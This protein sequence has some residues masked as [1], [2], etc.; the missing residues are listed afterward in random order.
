MARKRTKTRRGEG[1][2]QRI[3]A[4]GEGVFAS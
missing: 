4:G 3:E 2:R 1:A